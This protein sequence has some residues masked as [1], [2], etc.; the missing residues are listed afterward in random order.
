MMVR[1]EPTTRPPTPDPTPGRQVGAFLD[2][3]GSVLS[4]AA[5]SADTL[6]DRA[7]RLAADQMVEQATRPARKPGVA[8]RLGRW[9][10]G[11]GRPARAR[12]PKPTRVPVPTPAGGFAP[13][14][15]WMTWLGAWLD[16]TIGALPLLAPLAISGWYTSHAGH[17]ALGMPWPVAVTLTVALEGGVWKLSRLYEDTLVAGDSTIALRVGLFAYIGGIAGLIFWYATTSVDN[18]ADADW[19]PAAVVSAMS[20]A[21]FYVWSRRA[22]WRRRAELRAAGRVDTQ[23]VRFSVWSWLVAPLETAAALRYAVKHRID[24]PVEAIEAYRADRDLRRADRR[25]GRAAPKA[26]RQSAQQT[27][28]PDP[29]PTGRKSRKADPTPTAGTDP[30]PQAEPTADRSEKPT[31]SRRAALRSA[32]DEPILADLRAAYPTT[33]PSISQ[34]QAI[35][36]GSRSRAIRLRDLY[37]AEIEKTA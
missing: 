20:A 2:R 8:I 23:L 27:P 4:R 17:Y 15:A 24:R 18:L 10:F 31:R 22:R 29:A 6:T 32:D 26:D 35:A 21:G 9:L 14:P 11:L 36:G 16:R 37:R 3:S 30:R 7:V 1:M 19:R 33:V 13:V 12:A 34:V 25:H 28:T 5:E